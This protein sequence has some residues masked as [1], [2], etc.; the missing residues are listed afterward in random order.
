L[1]YA[2]VAAVLI[3]LIL[4]W[5]S[6]GGRNALPF[7][8]PSPSEIWQELVNH[9]LLLVRHATPT[10]VAAATGFLIATAVAFS[11]GALTVT[12]PRF[13]GPVYN[14]AATLYGMPLLALMPILI[15][16][17]GIGTTTRTVVAVVA[18]FF[19]VLAGTIQ[20]LN[21]A[22]NDR[23]STELFTVL[24]ATKPQRFSRQ[25]VPSSIPYI[26]AGLKAASASAVLGAIIAEW[27]GADRGLGV[28][29]IFS[30][31]SINVPRVWLTIIASAVLAIGAYGLVALVEKVVLAAKP[32][33]GGE[34]GTITTVSP[35]RSGE[36]S[37]RVRG[38]IKIA[39]TRVLAALFVVLA[40]QT[41]ISVF[42]VPSYI[43]PGPVEVGRSLVDEW[44]SLASH[45][46]Y[47]IQASAFGLALSSITA[48][49]L[50][51][52]IVIFPVM[53]RVVMPFSVAIRSL[54]IVAIAPLI[55]LFVG[56]G[57]KTSVVAVFIV[58][59]FPVFVNAVQ[60]F[61]N[62]SEAVGDLMR[63]LGARRWQRFRLARF[64]FALPFIFTGLRTAAATAV[65]G[66][67]LVEWLTGTRGLGFLILHGAAT[68]QLGLLWAVAVLSVVLSL[69]V[70]WSTGS[71]EKAV[72]QRMGE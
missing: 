62:V 23:S 11:I 18:S 16:W 39:L 63:V 25:L 10:L 50:A 15:V 6:A 5:E 24:S 68:R 71:V 65:L 66:A 29:M 9:P 38:L 42:R 54:P 56:R 14:A 72:A 26:F 13:R 12:W 44:A 8:V 4:V 33:L 64:P 41:A 60:G 36:A 61:D 40:W 7:S 19:P 27:T 59:F 45:A 35:S 31:F 1:A 20:G 32:G 43:M 46:W 53:R 34:Y 58:V 55:T 49:A 52:L 30:L 28:M 3:G 2:M 17:F 48:V 37:Q 69:T 22:Q 70:F 67:M 51:A 57:F 47:T 21:V